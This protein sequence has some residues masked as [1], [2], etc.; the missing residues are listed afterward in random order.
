MIL[1]LLAV[2][3]S[4]PVLIYSVDMVTVNFSFRAGDTNWDA[5]SFVLRCIDANTGEVLY[6]ADNFVSGQS[7]SFSV[8]RDAH[9]LVWCYVKRYGGPFVY[10]EFFDLA[11][12]KAQTGYGDSVYL[13]SEDEMGKCGDGKVSG[14][15][16]C[17]SDKDCSAPTPGCYD[18]ERCGCKDDKDCPQISGIKPCGYGRCGPEER[19]VI[20]NSCYNGVCIYPVMSCNYDPDCV[21]SDDEG[22][23]EEPTEE[24]QANQA[25]YRKQGMDKLA[26]IM[27]AINNNLESAPGFLKY[28]FGNQRINFDGG[29]EVLHG[30]TNERFLVSIGYGEQFEPTMNIHVQ[31]DAL[32]KIE[33]G[34]LSFTEAWE[35]GQITCEGVGFLNSVKFK[36]VNFV[37]GIYS[38]VSD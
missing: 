16:K 1:F 27:G 20:K 32:E 6:V 8:D 29:E 10:K 18:C 11:K 7:S 17:D 13:P 14:M 2:L 15:E 30:T 19:P 38:L 12:E 37:Y 33:S 21:K 9:P 5:H 25:E 26:S 36:I 24:E 28:I 35:S 22:N 31:K 23:E 4:F 3:V 34:E